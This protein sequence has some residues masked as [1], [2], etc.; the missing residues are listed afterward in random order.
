MPGTYHLRIGVEENLASNK[1]PIRIE[2]VD[3]VYVTAAID[4]TSAR[5][6]EPWDTSIP[7]IKVGIVEIKWMDGQYPIVNKE[8]KPPSCRETERKM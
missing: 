7:R 4:G 1:K 3:E 2:N 8:F 6:G 5:P